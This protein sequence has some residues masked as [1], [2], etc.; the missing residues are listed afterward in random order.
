MK[1]VAA[2]IWII[3]TTLFEFPFLHPPL[4]VLYLVTTPADRRSLIT[5]NRTRGCPAA[6]ATLRLAGSRTPS[7]FVYQ[8]VRAQTT[9]QTDILI[10]RNGDADAGTH[11]RANMWEA[12]DPLGLQT[13]PP[14]NYSKRRVT[15]KVKTVLE[16]SALSLRS[17][18][19]NNVHSVSPESQRS[20]WKVKSHAFKIKEDD[21]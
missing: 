19:K 2:L 12:S 3:S 10:N 1:G 9:L 8:R 11:F 14:P 15:F 4:F 20:V 5:T 7:L 21:I 16:E 13:P 6:A 17:T 18:G